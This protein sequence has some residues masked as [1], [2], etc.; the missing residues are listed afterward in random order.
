MP[1]TSK[2]YVFGS[3]LTLPGHEI[4]NR[5]AFYEATFFCVSPKNLLEDFLYSFNAG[6]TG[7][8][9]NP[10]E[11]LVGPSLVSEYWLL[12]DLFLLVINVCPVR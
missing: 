7:S 5:G 11:R 12:K 6:F 10:V 1:V 4:V 2:S 9:S 8:I 3:H